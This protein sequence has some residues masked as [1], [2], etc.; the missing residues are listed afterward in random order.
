MR[1]V[2]RRQSQVKKSHDDEVDLLEI[3]RALLQGKWV[4]FASFL[5]FFSTFIFYSLSLPNLYRSSAL[6]T[7]ADAADTGG[8]S[9]L[10]G[11]LGGLATI[12]GINLSSGGSNNS[13]EAIEVLQ[14][15]AFIEEFIEEQGIETQVFAVKEWD[16]VNDKLIFDLDIYNSDSEVW[17]RKPPK[18]G[19]SKPSSWELYDKFISEYMSIEEDALTG[20]TTISI[21]YYSPELS[22]VWVDELVKKIND[23][24]KKSNADTAERNLTYL[25]AQAAETKFASMQKVFYDLIEEQI[26]THMLAM[27]SNEYVFKT[28]REARVSEVKS[29]PKRSLIVSLGAI[30]GLIFGAILSL[31]LFM[32]RSP[33][34]RNK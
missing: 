22:K 27:G 28:V 10:A 24:F 18:G 31:F 30:L 21:E 2:S 34:L 1:G 17:T 6:V 19:D 8:L 9:G 13:A 15:W 3:G 7:P 32:A 20:F 12:A 33:R 4:I 11:Q 16:P 5:L 14:S 23:R 29:N 26:K 25:R